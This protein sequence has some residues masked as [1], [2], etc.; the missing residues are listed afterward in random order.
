MEELQGPLAGVRID[1][2][3]LVCVDQG[4][5]VLAWQ[6]AGARPVLWVSPAARYEEGRSVRGGA[7]VCFP[8]FGVGRGEPHEPVHG[9]VRT[10]PWERVAGDET[11]VE[12]RITDATTGAQP[13]WPH[14]YSATLRASVT[15]DSLRIELEVTNTGDE[16]VSF[17][18]AIHSYLAVGD[19][20]RVRV[21]GLDGAE[22]DDYVV[23]GSGKQVGDLVLEGHTD[24]VYRSA[25]DV[26][27]T[28]PTWERT[29][30]VHKEGSANTVVWNPWR[31]HATD[32]DDVPADGWQG[33]LCIEA[34]NAR[35]DAIFLAPGKSHVLAQEIALR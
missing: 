12:Y 23:G 1:E 24:R 19:V 34:A 7:P 6:P 28:D 22:F 30:L 32:M 29:L 16:E 13:R 8:W 15:P 35:D 2:G 17:E 21:E 5:Q 25:A 26:V 14:S 31:E 33:M 18:N 20:E 4:A 3:R 11:H 9:F 27:V 10:A